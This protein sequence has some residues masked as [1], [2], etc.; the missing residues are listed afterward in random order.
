M[1][2]AAFKPAPHLQMM[3][4][5]SGATTPEELVTHVRESMDN[6]EYP[7]D[8]SEDVFHIHMDRFEVW[9]LG[10][11]TKQIP[12]LKIGIDPFNEVIH[13]LS[14]AYHLK[15]LGNKNDRRLLQNADSHSTHL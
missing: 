8:S 11:M 12:G 6:F 7:A 2:Y 13:G 9:C 5:E 14:N 1:L 15:C 3:I 4:L 10:V